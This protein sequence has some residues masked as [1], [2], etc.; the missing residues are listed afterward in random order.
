VKGVPGWMLDTSETRNASLCVL[1][2]PWP[3]REE[4]IPPPTTDRARRVEPRL[5]R[6]RG[7]GGKAAMIPLKKRT[8]LVSS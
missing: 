8:S 5:R 1:L 4:G 2:N 7:P 3:E 6:P